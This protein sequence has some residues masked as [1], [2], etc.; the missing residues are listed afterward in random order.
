MSVTMDDSI[1]LDLHRFRSGQVRILGGS[2]FEGH[3]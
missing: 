1:K 2:L 3:G